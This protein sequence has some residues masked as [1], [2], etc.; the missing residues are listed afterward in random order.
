MLSQATI[1]TVDDYWAAFF[2]CSPMLLYES[3]TTI[4]PHA[5]LADYNGLFFF[6]RGQALIISIPPHMLERGRELFHDLTS[7]SLDDIDRI[8][9]RIDERDMRIVGPA[10]I[11]YTEPAIF[12]A[13]SD[14]GV[15]LLH[16]KDAAAFES[17]HRACPP[18]EWEHGGSPWGAQPIAGR[19]K[20]HELAA[21]ASYE[22]WGDRIAHIAVVTHPTYRGRGY[23]KGVVSAITQTALQN[24]LIPQYRTLIANHP[25]MAIAAELGF[26]GYA[27]SIALRLT[28]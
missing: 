7:A 15:R 6:R 23:G 26:V 9:D 13:A 28:A 1:A 22:V 19:F 12:T 2:G 25:S 10:F 8:V 4:V 17:F 21:L 14:Q 20:D 11:G 5:G 16:H 18:L 27:E 3:A 24:N